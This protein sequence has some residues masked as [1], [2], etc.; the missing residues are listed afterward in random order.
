MKTLAFT[1]AGLAVLAA[2]PSSVSAQ[3]GQWETIGTKTVGSRVDRDTIDVKGR[4]RHR[5]VRICAINRPLNLYDVDFRFANGGKQDAQT[6]HRLTKGSCT[7][8][9][10]LKGKRRNLSKVDLAYSRTGQG[11]FFPPIVRVQ[12][13]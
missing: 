2:S 6:R 7:R 13:R 1:I 8:A 5:Q 9:I 12:A 4:D 11:G 10:D 3:Q